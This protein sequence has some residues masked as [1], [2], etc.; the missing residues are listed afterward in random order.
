MAD[1]GG[2]TVVAFGFGGNSRSFAIAFDAIAAVANLA[3]IAVDEIHKA[4]SGELQMAISTCVQQS[5]G[6]I[7]N[8]QSQILSLQALIQNEHKQIMNNDDNNR[9]LVMTNLEMVK[10][11]LIKILNKPLGQ[12]SEFPIILE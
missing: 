5:A 2:Q 4:E 8:L 9:D 3:Y 12:R 7:A 6:D 10:D 11:E 1:A